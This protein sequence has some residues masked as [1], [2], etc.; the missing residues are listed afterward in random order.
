MGGTN[1]FPY[2]VCLFPQTLGLKM[3]KQMTAY[4]IFFLIFGKPYK[5]SPVI[6]FSGL[7]P[8]VLLTFFAFDEIIL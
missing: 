5:F 8:T 7:P 4:H 6:Y 2:S 3:K 1:P